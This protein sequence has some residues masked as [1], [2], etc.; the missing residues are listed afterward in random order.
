MYY[1][2]LFSCSFHISTLT[3]VYCPELPF[4]VLFVSIVSDLHVLYCDYKNCRSTILDNYTMHYP[5][6]SL[7]HYAQ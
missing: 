5:Y 7:E 3:Q 6:A 4:S 1:C 2:M